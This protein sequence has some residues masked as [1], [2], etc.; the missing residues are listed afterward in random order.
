LASVGVNSLVKNS[1]S[2]YIA[3]VI[4]LAGNPAQLVLLSGDLRQRMLSPPL[5]DASTFTRELERKLMQSWE[6]PSCLEGSA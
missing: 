3:T 2:R 5:M 6:E 1:E 4:A